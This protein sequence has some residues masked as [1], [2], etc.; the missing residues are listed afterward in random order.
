DLVCYSFEAL[1]AW[2]WEQNLA[3]QADET[4]L[5]FAERLGRETPN[6]TAEVRRLANLYARVAYAHGR[7]PAMAVEVV[8]QF[9]RQIEDVVESPLSAYGPCFFRLGL[10]VSRVIVSTWCYSAFAQQS[11]CGV[12]GFPSGAS[13]RSFSIVSAWGR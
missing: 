4:P 3:R 10:A 9:W 5:E 13:A 11:S 2:A 6:L 7:L 8:R 1:E 12:V